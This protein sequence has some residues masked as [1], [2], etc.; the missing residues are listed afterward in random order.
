MDTY[1]L[2]GK[3]LKHSFSKR[4]FTEKFER[5]GISAQY[6]LFELDQISRFPDL[7]QSQPG[8]RGLNVTIPYKTEVIPFLDWLSPAVEEIGAV[9]CI[10]PGRHGLEGHNTDVLGFERSLREQWQGEWPEQALILGNGGAA[11]AVAFVLKN[12][13]GIQQIRTA[14]RS[15]KGPGERDY[16][17]LGQL[18]WAACRLIVNTTPLGMYPDVES[19]PPIPYDKLGPAHLAMD[20]VYNPAETAFMR[21][22]AAQG[23]RVAN[24]L[25][26]LIYQAEAAWEIWTRD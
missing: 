8:L 3:T 7:W 14:T 9:N 22:A 25:D 5:E 17:S 12:L 11:K 26:M 6:E 19:L 18:D 15:P 13:P 4:Y 16:A 1:G 10:R 23:A 2:I 24:G 20:L 21:A